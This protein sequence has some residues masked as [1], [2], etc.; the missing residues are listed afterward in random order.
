MASLSPN[1]FA[2]KDGELER[3]AKSFSACR[4]FTEDIIHSMRG[5]LITTDLKR[6][7]LAV[8]SHGRGNLGLPLL[9]LHGKRP[10]I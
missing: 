5:G 8:E 9:E 1:R 2:A 7:H 4:I 3:S 10:R 6:P